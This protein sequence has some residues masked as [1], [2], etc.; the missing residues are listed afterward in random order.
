MAQINANRLAIEYED[1]GNRDDPVILLVMGFSWQLIHWPDELVFGL[2]D[3]GFRVIRFDNRDAGLSEKIDTGGK[4]NLGQTL[5]ALA[6]GD[7]P[8][9][10]YTLFDMADDTIGLLDALDIP[11]CHVVG[12]SMGGM[13]A[14][15][16]AARHPDRVLTLTSIM[17]SSGSPGLPG[18]TEEVS[19]VLLSAPENP[20]D[21]ESVIEHGM[22]LRRAIGGS[23][24]PTPEPELRA[25]IEQTID[26]SVYTPGVARQYVAIAASG[27]RTA[28]LPGITVPSLVI[29]GSEDPLTPLPCGEDTAA[30]IPGAV[31]RIIDGLGHEVP[32]AVMPQWVD[33]I[34]SHIGASSPS[35]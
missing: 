3:C 16:V 21:R 5:A 1:H 29:H 19:R 9:V 6:A 32:K 34:V 13:I 7:N 2:V 24:F 18:P 33:M 26:R 25:I 27:A 30:L 10:P 22:M 4:I 28:L 8:D 11:Q 17:S 20:A 15:I 23:A 31:L 14:Q 35:S 12:L